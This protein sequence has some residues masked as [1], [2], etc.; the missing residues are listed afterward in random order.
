[1]GTAA[2]AVGGAG[3]GGMA[4]EAGRR[5][6]RQLRGLDAPQ[7]TDENA[8][9][10]AK[11]GAIQGGI[12]AASEALPLA[13]PFLKN[14]A[15]GQYTRALAPTTQANKAITQ[16]IA[17][18]MIRR[19]LHGNLESL[20]ERAGA[21]T[22]AVGPDLTAAYAA[23][24][25]KATEGS[26]SKILSDLEGMK[27]R[28]VVDGQVANPEAVNAIS[29]VQDI[30]KQYGNDV[31]PQ[32]LR[33]LKQIFD[34]PVAGAGG[35]T[36]TDLATHYSLNAKEAAAN[37]IRNILHQA[38]PDAAALDKEI[39]F[40]L[41]VKRVTGATNL[42]RAGQEGGLLKTLSPL[43]AGAAGAL[44]FATHGTTR[45]I[46]AG[47][48]AALATYAAQMVRTPA[49]RTTSAI[50]KDRLADALARGSVGDVSALG[51]RLGLDSLSDMWDQ[52]ATSK[53]EAAGSPVPASRP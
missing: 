47:A 46:E 11:Q 38:S 10:I 18:Q 22:A 51:V 20:E 50:F 2:G 42:R 1:M 33:K 6:Y 14:A 49:W 17:P 19:G 45:S 34:E 36:G 25:A 16:D 24:P 29:G 43:G 48:G 52:T 3:M 35:Y 32:S 8:T 30:V 21:E 23:V 31:S 12:Q 7:S 53:P 26:G 15:L 27:N 28:Y 5:F 39:S 13:A 9:G 41:N 37:S 44:G 4:G 40:W